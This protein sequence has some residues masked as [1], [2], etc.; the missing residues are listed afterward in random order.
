MKENGTDGMWE[1]ILERGNLKRA[2][3]QVRSNHGAPGVDG[4]RI[5]AFPAWAKAHWGEIAS[6]LKEE[7]YRPEAVRRTEI[8]KPGGGKR[9]LGIPTARPPADHRDSLPPPRCWIG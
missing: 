9:L 8:D 1:A 5:E 6:Q 7:R 3:K 2:W 4:M